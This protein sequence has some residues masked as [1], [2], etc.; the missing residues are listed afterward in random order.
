MKTKMKKPFEP[1]KPVPYLIVILLILFVL[2]IGIKTSSTARRTFDGDLQRNLSQ[3]QSILDG[4]PLADPNYLGEKIWYNPLVPGLAA[5]ISKVSGAPPDIVNLR[6]GA[7]LN[8]LTPVCFFVLLL[9]AFDAVTAAASVFAMLFIITAGLPV[10]FTGTYS[11]IMY[12]L[13]LAPAFFFIGLAFYIKA[14]ETA[15]L[16]WHLLTGLFLGLTFLAHTAPA[17]ILGSVILVNT[18]SEIRT[19]RQKQTGQVELS[20]RRKRALSGFS[21]SMITAFAVSLPFLYSILFHYRMKIINPVPMDFTE[22]ILQLNHFT[23]FVSAAAPHWIVAILILIG[24]VVLI[25]KRNSSE[26]YRLF[27]MLS[28]IIIAL[29]SYNYARQ[30]IKFMYLPLIVPSLHFV[31]YLTILEAL[32]FGLGSSYVI[33]RASSAAIK[34]VQKAGIKIHDLH[35]PERILC[36][37]LLTLPMITAFLLMKSGYEAREDYMQLKHS[38]VT[39]RLN[40]SYDLL[41][42]WT[43]EST[44][45]DDVFFNDKEAPGYILMT[46][47][48]F[49]VNPGG[50]QFSNPYVDYQKRLKDRNLMIQALEY[51]RYDA[52]YSKALEYK[53]GWVITDAKTCADYWDNP[54]FLKKAFSSKGTAVYKIDLDELRKASAD[55]MPSAAEP[56]TALAGYPWDVT[57]F[58]IQPRNFN[59]F[60]S[61]SLSGTMRGWRW[62]NVTEGKQR[63]IVLR[64]YLERLTGDRIVIARRKD[65]MEFLRSDEFGKLDKSGLLFCGFARQ[66][67]VLKLQSTFPEKVIIASVKSGIWKTMKSYRP[68]IFPL[69]TAQTIAR[70]FGQD[71]LSYLRS[72]YAFVF[73]AEW[74]MKYLDYWLEKLKAGKARREDIFD[75]LLI[76]AAEIYY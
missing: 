41:Y 39:Q 56:Y 63:M 15:G 18:I 74:K 22:T 32:L 67:N 51:K 49:V 76:Q 71:D 7:F 54:R 72:A 30:A 69:S 65:M 13:H 4:A 55:E 43:L 6:A 68:E 19:G 8:I 1:I 5:L 16:K 50:E 40:K 23:S 38:K 2:S 57:V 45:P 42:K 48:K 3:A 62:I 20:R 73:N 21:L 36:T 70:S 17:V 60:E 10:Y 26:A 34:I 61:E 29:M 44:A 25:R 66:R 24:F 33:I 58:C 59:I 11:P 27:F 75:S 35:K 53:T 14:V 28:V 31:V 64:K 37:L 9:I 52:F 12:S 47:R 46:G